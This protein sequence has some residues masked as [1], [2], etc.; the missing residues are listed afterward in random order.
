[1]GKRQEL[2]RISRT[3][4][5]IAF[6]TCTMGTYEIFLT[7][8]TQGLIAD[9]SAGLFWSLVWVYV[10]QASA[11]LSLAE[12]ASIAPTAG[13]QYHWVSEFAS[14]KYQKILSYL[15]GWLSML[16]WQSF[17]AVDS[18]LVG[19]VILGILA[20][21]DQSFSPQRWKATL[22]IIAT[23]LAIAASNFFAYAENLFFAPKSRRQR[24]S[25]PNLRTL[26]LVGAQ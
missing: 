8:N 17:V 6:T 2:R 11:M 3:L 25:L 15:S 5:F 14:R 12:M 19:E 7:A 10:G 4:S 20:I 22:L 13:G 1:M 24:L 26:G 18:F 9:D 21:N 23:V 16:A